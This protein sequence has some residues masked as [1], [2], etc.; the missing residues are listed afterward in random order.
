MRSSMYDLV[1]NSLDNRLLSRESYIKSNYNEIYNEIMLHMSDIDILFKER[2]FLYYKQ[3][4]SV[5]VCCSVGCENKVSFIN[6]SKG[7]RKYCSNSCSS[8]N[9]TSKRK[10]TMLE[11]YGVEHALQGEEFKVKFKQT[12]E[13][14]YGFDNPSKNELIK[15]KRVS[16]CVSKYGVETPLKFK[17][18]SDR[19]IKTNIDRYGTPSYFGSEIA[20]ECNKSLYINRNSSNV[21]VA[22]IELY[23]IIKS[24]YND[25]II[26][27]DRQIL[28]GYELDI[29]LPDVKIAFEY[30]GLY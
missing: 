27:N 17:E 11:K 7:H 26:R 16:T 14:R 4:F 6:I 23:N 24:I 19:I 12:S 10:K 25:D 21:S 15:C 9:S 1:Y 20:I 5:P 28:N 13:A 22:E 3:L 18:F 2:S 29:Y 30:N 8:I